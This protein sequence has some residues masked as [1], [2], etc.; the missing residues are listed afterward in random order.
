[1]MSLSEPHRLCIF[2]LASTRYFLVVMFGLISRSILD[3]RPAGS[4]DIDDVEHDVSI[5]ELIRI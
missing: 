3:G 1:M 4:C 5:P 2:A